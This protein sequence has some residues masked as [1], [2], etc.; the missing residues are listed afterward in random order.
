MH[1]KDESDIYYNII[2]Q[3]LMHNLDELIVA[4]LIH[5]YQGYPTIRNS[6]DK[7]KCILETCNV[8]KKK[9]MRKMYRFPR[10]TL[11]VFG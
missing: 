2:L 8:K 4:F 7:M 1:T 11:E 9:C 10:I 3:F 5:K 6:F